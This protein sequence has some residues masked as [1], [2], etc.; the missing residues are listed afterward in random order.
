MLLLDLSTMTTITEQQFRARYTTTV[1]P[2]VLTPASLEGFGVAIFNIAPQPASSPLYSVAPNGFTPN[3][4]GTYTMQ[5]AMT[6]LPLAQIQQNLLGLVGQ[7][8]KTAMAQTV[9]YLNAK[10]ALDTS[11]FHVWKTITTPTPV[12]ST[13]GQWLIFQSGDVDNVTN[14]ITTAILSVNQNEYTHY[15]AIQNLT[16]ETALTYDVTTGWIV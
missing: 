6:P 16:E 2:N 4:N 7:Q 1:F 9:S 12:K 13:D 11:S 8:K 15:I 10:F 5:W 3:A 14:M